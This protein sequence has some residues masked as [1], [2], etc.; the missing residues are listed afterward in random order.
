MKIHCKA[1]GLRNV[2]YTPEG[3]VIGIRYKSPES[4]KAV[5]GFFSSNSH[6]VG[7]DQTSFVPVGSVINNGD[8]DFG[9]SYDGGV[10]VQIEDDVVNS[11]TI[12]PG[13]GEDQVH[14]RLTIALDERL[15]LAE[16]GFQ[17]LYQTFGDDFIFPDQIIVIATRVGALL[18]TNSTTGVW[19]R[20]I[21]ASRPSWIVC[22]CFP[23]EPQSPPW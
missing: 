5:V 23:P 4:G 11:F 2:E 7:N 9:I 8:A 22:G 12:I 15:E 3:R 1:A 21:C 18:A 20:K 13:C 6:A 17:I 19:M 14:F 16:G 10:C